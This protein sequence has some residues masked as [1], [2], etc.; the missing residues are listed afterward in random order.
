MLLHFFQEVK[1]SYRAIPCR[2]QRLE[3]PTCRNLFW[4][5][6]PPY[7]LSLMILALG[8]HNVVGVTR[9]AK[10]RSLWRFHNFHHGMSTLHYTF[11]M[12]QASVGGIPLF[13]VAQELFG[14]WL[15]EITLM[16]RSRGCPSIWA[17]LRCLPCL[18]GAWRN[19][20]F[21][22][23][24]ATW[25]RIDLMGCDAQMAALCHDVD[26]RGC[27]NIVRICGGC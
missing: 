16:V 10:L 25:L 24:H 14:T 19:W 8:D 13:S 17:T 18:S 1:A 7:A 9:D 27:P 15:V 23:R 22:G 11:K 5:N 2:A 26:H 20:K 21:L 4:P 12:I 6:K 3:H